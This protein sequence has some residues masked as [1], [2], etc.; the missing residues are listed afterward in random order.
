M[1]KPTGYV[2]MLMKALKK[3][4]V[5]FRPEAYDG[6]KHV[7]LSIPSSKINIEI[8]GNQHL[9]DAT[10]IVSDLARSGHSGKDDYATMHIPN[11]EIKRNVGGIASAIAEASA[12]REE[13]FQNKSK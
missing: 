5:H 6:Y 10:Q 3:L 13:Q 8:D 1:P 11:T 12:I 9:T 4:K 7:D 2:F